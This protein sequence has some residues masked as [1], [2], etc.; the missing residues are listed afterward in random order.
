MQHLNRKGLDLQ[1]DAGDLAA[2]I[3]LVAAG[4]LAEFGEADMPA[5]AQ[6]QAGGDH[7]AVDIDAGL[8]LE[9]EE[10]VH[11]AGIVCAAAEDPSA[12]A[13]DRAGQD[14][15]QPRGVL[16]GDGLHLHRPWNADGLRS[17]ACRRR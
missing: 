12:T 2:A 6:L 7:D 10:H 17:V 14:L 9:L 5:L 3:L 15:N 1:V 4:A 11:G 13:E 16:D 8:P